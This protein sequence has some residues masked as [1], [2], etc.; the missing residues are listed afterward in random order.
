M[1]RATGA[2]HER[3]GCGKLM[4]ARLRQK[5]GVGMAFEVGVASGRGESVNKD[6]GKCRGTRGA[7]A[8]VRAGSRQ[9]HDGNSER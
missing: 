4:S 5:L 8:G 7:A 1:A 3:K 2:D 6:N 9:G